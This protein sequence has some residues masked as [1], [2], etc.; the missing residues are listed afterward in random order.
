M[1]HYIFNQPKKSRTICSTH[2]KKN[3][4][5]RVIRGANYERIESLVQLNKALLNLSPSISG[6]SVDMLNCK[7]A[8]VKFLDAAILIANLDLYNGI[9]RGDIIKKLS[10]LVEEIIC[11]TSFNF[12]YDSHGDKHF[13]G[14]PRGT[15]FTANKDTVNPKIEEIINKYKGQIRKYAN[16]EEVTLYYTGDRID[17]CPKDI[18][19]LTI[20]LTFSPSSNTVQYHAYPDDSIRC[21]SLSTTKGGSN[22]FRY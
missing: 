17:E 14:G 2:I 19:G 10:P 1:K 11:N 9:R 7:G 3:L 8:N 12:E 18:R 20:Q 15:K 13:P 4:F 16:G 22:I 5:Q 21:N 6:I